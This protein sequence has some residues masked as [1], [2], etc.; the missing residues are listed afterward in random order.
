MGGVRTEEKIYFRLK[1]LLPH[2]V[3]RLFSEQTTVKTRMRV[4]MAEQFC[5]P[6]NFS[7]APTAVMNNDWS[8]GLIYSNV[9]TGNQS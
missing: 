8:L 5:N 1:N 3:T 7:S 2:L 9:M 4:K 6:S